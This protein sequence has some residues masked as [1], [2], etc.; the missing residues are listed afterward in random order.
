MLRAFVTTENPLQ[1]Q[2]ATVIALLGCEEGGGVWI[3]PG[4]AAARRA[5]DAARAHFARDGLGDQIALLR[6]YA[7]WDA[8]GRNARWC[9]ERFIHARALG[10]CVPCAQTFGLN[11]CKSQSCMVCH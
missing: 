5:A 10:L 1:N 6:C 9:Q 8:N 3:R 11:V 4:E 7:D 2:V